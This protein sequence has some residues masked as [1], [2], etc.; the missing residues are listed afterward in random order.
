[1]SISLTEGLGFSIVMFIP[2]DNLFNSKIN[3]G[4]GGTKK[5]VANV[6]NVSSDHCPDSLV[7]NTPTL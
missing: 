6:T 7:T 4:V 3:V 1:M 2:A 5:S